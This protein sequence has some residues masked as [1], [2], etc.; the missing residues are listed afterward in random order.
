MVQQ[1]GE[2][3]EAR[4]RWLTWLERHLATSDRPH[5]PELDAAVRA[6]LRRVRHPRLFAMVDRARALL[7]G[8]R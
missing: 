7:R 2:G 4:L 3:D 1:R 5:D 8:A 6:A